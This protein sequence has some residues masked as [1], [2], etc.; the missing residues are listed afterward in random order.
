[1][2][3]V[4]TTSAQDGGNR[5][6]GTRPQLAVVV[7]VHN[8]ADNIE[9]LIAEI[10]Q[11]LDGRFDYE[12]VYVDDASSDATADTLAAAAKS[13][14]ALRVVRHRQRSGQ[15]AAV[16][17]G[18]TAARAPVIATLDG[19]GQN[20]PADIPALV[21]RLQEAANPDRLLVAGMRAKR[22][23]TLVK[24]LSSKIAN[25]VRRG[26]L[27]DGTPDTGCG[28]KVFTRNAFLAMPRFDHMHRFL[29]ALML[30]LNG[31]VVSVAV[32]HRHR[33][34]GTTKYGTFDRLWVGITDLFGVLWLMRRAITPESDEVGP[35]AGG[36]SGA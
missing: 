21:A 29:P 24:R 25:R 31:E 10:V 17:T 9:T 3:E 2:T 28:L 18:V 26:L 11:A 22:R 20:D 32:N 36:R 7:P 35:D 15:S 14:A 19:D 16:A 34:R 5:P 12:I 1:M 33:A 23:D 27:G 8:E 30:R 13:Y 6:A 4:Q